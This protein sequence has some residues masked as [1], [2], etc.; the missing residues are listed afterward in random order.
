MGK[1]IVL[2]IGQCSCSDCFFLDDTNQRC[3]M[4]SDYMYINS[5]SQCGTDNRQSQLT[6]FL[7][8]LFLSSTGAANFYIGRNDLG[9]S[10]THTHTKPFFTF[11][12]IFY[13]LKAGGQ[14]FLLI[15][16]YA[17][18]YTTCCLPCCLACCMEKSEI[19]GALIF[20]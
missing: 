4:C 8:S 11:F 15:L 3:R 18:S 5:S 10:H 6:A 13:P 20:T 1:K 7:L 17:L 2:H 14:L 16:L 12:S 19:K 9:C